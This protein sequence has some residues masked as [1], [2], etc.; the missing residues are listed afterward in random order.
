MKIECDTLSSCR[1]QKSSILLYH[2]YYHVL[3]KTSYLFF[4]F[5]SPLIDSSFIFH[6]RWPEFLGSL[7]SSPA[8]SLTRGQPAQHTNTADG[9]QNLKVSPPLQIIVAILTLLFISCP[10]INTNIYQLFLYLTLLFISC[11]VVA[12]RGG[13]LAGWG[14]LMPV[15][16]CPGPPPV[17]AGHSHAEIASGPSQ[18]EGSKH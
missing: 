11:E 14:E 12:W 8:P 2:A 6:C 17:L 5:T 13:R 18:S 7:S 9:R 16:A 4:H 15:P 3:S 1:S 10:S